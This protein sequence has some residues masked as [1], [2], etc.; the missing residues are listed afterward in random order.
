MTNYYTKVIDDATH[1]YNIVSSE[2]TTEIVESEDQYKV[3]P[4]DKDRTWLDQH[5][6][7]IKEEDF[8]EIVDHIS[9]YA[10]LGTHPACPPGGCQ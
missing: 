1:Y 6:D 3:I 5:A 9:D 2:L 4:S 10:R 8:D 7:E